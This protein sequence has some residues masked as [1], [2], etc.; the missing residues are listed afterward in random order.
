MEAEE[1]E[2]HLLQEKLENSALR[3]RHRETWTIFGETK[4]CLLTVEEV[5]GG[6]VAKQ[7]A[8]LLTETAGVTD[9]SGGQLGVMP[10]A[11]AA[12]QTASVV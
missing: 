8:A 3:L 2:D 7:V 1:E 10:A 12:H 4:V 6:G 11:G 5:V 9:G